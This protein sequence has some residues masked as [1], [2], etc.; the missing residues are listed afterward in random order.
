MNSFSKYQYPLFLMI[1]I[2]IIIGF[3]FQKPLTGEYLFGGPDSLS[4]SAIKQGIKLAED[5]NGEYPLWL[6]W[7]FSGLPSVH[8]FQ[9]ISE[10]YFPDFMVDIFKIM[11]FPTFWNYVF[12]FILAGLGMFLL[13]KQIGLTNLC[14]F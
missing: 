6:P 4:P 7:V 12:H 1:S 2:I 13:I 9:N 8:S 10:F 14:S 11:G 5:E 3:L